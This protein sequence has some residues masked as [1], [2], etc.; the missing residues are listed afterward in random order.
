MSVLFN[1][2]Y[3]GDTDHAAQGVEYPP[4]SAPDMR[5]AAPDQAPKN[6]GTLPGDLAHDPLLR[7]S[8][9]PLGGASLVSRIKHLFS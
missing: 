7:R 8:P 1:K 6:G 2:L 4:G 3:P 9:R 5:Q